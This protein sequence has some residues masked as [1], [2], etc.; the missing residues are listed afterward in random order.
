METGD[1]DGDLSEAAKALDLPPTQVP[2]EEPRKEPAQQRPAG[3]RAPEEQKEPDDSDQAGAPSTAPSDPA[4][5]PLARFSRLR[6]WLSVFVVTLASGLL[7]QVSAATTQTGDTDSDLV[8]LVRQRQEDVASL[9][10]A[11][12]DIAAQAD[13]LVNATAPGTSH[14]PVDEAAAALNGPVSGPG[15]VVTLT[16]APPGE[17]PEGLTANDL[18]IHQ[19]DIE[20]VMNALWEGG[21]EAMTVQGERISSRTVVRCI[22]NVILVGGTSYAPPYEIAAIG[23]A[24]T[25]VATVEA[26]PRVVNY[27]KYVALYGLGWNMETRDRISMPGTSQ[28]AVL[29]Y[30]KVVE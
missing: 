23:D 4:P 7:F 16:D 25:L 21:A 3:P 9:Q 13:A 26:N 10:S 8:G 24:D 29:T 12:D 18:V 30:A 15:V 20:D 17:I 14:A 11:R 22:G 6:S 19:Q 2:A 27:R 1:A 5:T 28:D